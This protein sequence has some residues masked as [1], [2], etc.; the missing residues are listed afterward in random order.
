MDLDIK[1]QLK[2]KKN[3]IRASGQ[4]I[5]S[6]NLTFKSKVHYT[7]AVSIQQPVKHRCHFIKLSKRN[8]MLCPC[9]L[10]PEINTAQF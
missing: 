2:L 4:T 7:V 9:F 5:L 10:T 1:Q 6:S 8:H 3:K